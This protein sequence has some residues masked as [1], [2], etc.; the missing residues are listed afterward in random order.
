MAVRV[1]IVEFN[2]E[3]TE[4]DVTEFQGWLHD[5]AARVPYL[6]RMQCGPHST[7]PT[8]KELSLNAPSVS[9]GHFV[10]VWEFADKNALNQF[11]KEPFHKEIAGKKFKKLVKHRYVVN[12]L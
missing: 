6:I 4:Q 8:D 5:L 11:V 3:V 2:P 9:F 1:V 7:L 12:F 10:S